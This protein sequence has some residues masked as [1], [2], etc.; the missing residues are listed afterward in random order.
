M[1]ELHAKL[2]N[3]NINHDNSNTNNNQDKSIL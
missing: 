1:V 2:D 3:I